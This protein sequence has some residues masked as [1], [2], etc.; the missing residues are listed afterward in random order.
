MAYTLAHLAVAQTV[1]AL[2]PELVEYKDS[3]YM[4]CIAPDA[5][6]SKEG[7]VR[8]DKKFVHLRLGITDMEWLQPEKM[9]I[10][11]KRLKEFT[12][13]ELY[14]EKDPKQRDFLIGYIVHLITDKV[15]HG[16]VR[17]RI[18]RKLETQGFEDGKW[19][20]I[21]H[22]L[23]ELEALD[24]YLL[25]S[26]PDIKALFYRLMELPVTNWLPGYI[27]KEYIE[28]SIYWWKNEYI[29]QIAQRRAEIV[30]NREIDIFIAL[31]SERILEELKNLNI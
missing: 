21:L 8:D 30:E 6:E 18:L 31:A 23:N 13:A 16:T 20:F 10:F 26:R 11:D 25:K 4:G 27:E 19:P 15:N 3:F 5:I 9:A 14:N 12:S 1:L 29:P 17:L 7:C 22:V 28:K 2:R 24:D